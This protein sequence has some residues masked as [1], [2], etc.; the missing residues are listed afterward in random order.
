MSTPGGGV[1][2]GLNSS[3]STGAHSVSPLT[4]RGQGQKRHSSTA[5]PDRSRHPRSAAEPARPSEGRPPSSSSRLI[6]C[7]TPE[8]PRISEGGRRRCR[9]TRAS[10]RIR[11]R[12]EELSRPHRCAKSMRI[13]GIP[14]FARI[15]H[16]QA[17]HFS[18]CSES[19]IVAVAVAVAGSRTSPPLF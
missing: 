1:L 12:T 13:G 2:R 5:E 7:E 10:T 11:R 19:V 4:R 3:A 16:S 18:L 17:L 8:N 9:R 15:F 14:G 6:S